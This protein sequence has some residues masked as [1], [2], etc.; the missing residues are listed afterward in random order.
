MAARDDEI[1]EATVTSK[2]QVTVPGQVRQILKLEPGDKIKFV[3]SA[4]GRVT[5]ETRKYRSI[6]SIARENTL[7]TLPQ[8]LDLNAAIERSVAGAADDRERR[9]GARKR[10]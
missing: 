7:P 3:R 10:K 6:L 1:G 5:I 8:G 4:S 2:G 9:S